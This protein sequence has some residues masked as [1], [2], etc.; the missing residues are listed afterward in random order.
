LA[1]ATE[2]AERWADLRSS[3][4]DLRTLLMLDAATQYHFDEFLEANEFEVALHALCDYLLEQPVMSVGLEEIRRI[5]DLH[6]K[7]QLR[8]ECSAELRARYRLNCSSEA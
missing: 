1:V 8:D 4:L 2:L 3:L 5:E 7:M 6:Q